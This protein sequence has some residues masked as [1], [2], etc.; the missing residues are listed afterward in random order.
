MPVKSVQGVLCCGNVVFDI[1]VWP[2][3]NFDW[4][5][6]TWVDTISEGIGGNGANTSYTLATLGVPVRLISTLGSDTQGQRL[7][8]ILSGAG[9][10]VSTLARTTDYSTP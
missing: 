5:T 2:V 1:A 8:E 10:D 6:T 9:V 3:D 4:N 7:T